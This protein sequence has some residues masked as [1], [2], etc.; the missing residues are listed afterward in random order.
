[1]NILVTGGAGFIGSHLIK[2]LLKEKHNVV[3]IDNYSTGKKEYE[4]EGCEYHE[5]DIRDIINYD[6]FMEN[7][8]VV[9]H[10]AGQPRL[11]PSFDLPGTTFDINASAT[12]ELLE[13]V[14]YKENCHFIYGSSSTVP[15]L[16]RNPY[17][18][19]KEVAEGLCSLYRKC[20]GVKA[21]VCRF[22]NVYGDRQISEGIYS[23]V[24]GKWIKQYKDNE[25]LTIT[26][27]GEQTRDFTHVDDIVEGLIEMLS[28]DETSQMTIG[29]GNGESTSINEVADMFGKDY[30]K[31]YIDSYPGEELHSRC[32]VERTKTEIKWNPKNSLSEYIK[33]EIG[34]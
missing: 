31:E 11:Q 26:G 19:S 23:T 2:R 6:S 14:R 30:P 16:E 29:L 34:E 3:C 28:I 25:P 22:Y 18:F 27:N 7:P 5:A 4:Y 17:S 33:R 15:S 8:D 12:L 21:N 9:Y 13:W 32:N 10:L 24:I 1:M 20:Y